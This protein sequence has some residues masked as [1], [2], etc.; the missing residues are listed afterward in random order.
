VSRA[1]LF[2][3]IIR[4][5]V[6][7]FEPLAR[8]ARGTIPALALF[9]LGSSGALL[10]VES[11]T[12]PMPWLLLASATTGCY[13]VARS[14]FSSGIGRV[15]RGAA[16][17]LI[18]LLLAIWMYEAALCGSMLSW[19]L[20]WW[21]W[22]LV[23]VLAAASAASASRQWA[24]LAVPWALPIGVFCSACLLGWAREEWR[25]RCDD[26]LAVTA[27]RSV[28]IAVPVRDDLE[29]CAPGE[30][31]AI[32]LYPRKVWPAADGNRV[33]FT[34][35]QAI[36]EAFRPPAVPSRISG[37]VCESE[38]RVEGGR[39]TPRIACL[40]A[41]GKAH[42]IVED[43][44][45]DRLLVGVLSGLDGRAG[46]IV[47]VSRSAPLREIGRVVLP[48]GGNF[49][50]DP[51]SDRLGEFGDEGRELDFVRAS[52]FT[53]LERGMP[54]SFLGPDFIRYDAQRHEGV[55]CSASGPLRT[56]DGDAPLAVAFQGVP[57][58][59]RPLAPSSRYPSSWLA[60]SW[61]CDWSVDRQRVF[62]AV[63]SLGQIVTIDRSSGDVTGRSFV[64]LGVRPLTYDPRRNVLFA[65]NF[66]R[67]DVLV[68][69]VATGSVVRR[70]FAG[71]YVRDIELTRD[72]NAILITSNVGIVRI[73]LDG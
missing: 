42:A 39:P 37:L 20:H 71:R 17:G 60:L 46:G 22:A 52:D 58:S 63:S 15:A 54:A 33:V 32:G 3:A 8:G 51:E 28:R 45:R 30:S 2:A 40:I 38:E 64:G 50:L 34:T 23:F 26:V 19:T 27:Q 66:L 53:V 4:T 24:R 9:F 48:Q 35:Q 5:V 69:D 1:S 16:R 44:D 12:G 25:V 43:P 41:Q 18:A 13:A 61:G 49:F 6:P 21:T 73:D 65:G 10:F 59:A 72:G 36:H 62:V 68:F 67:G 31:L 70:W 29:R 14:S 47:A 56:L 55:A 11:V 7:P 57:F